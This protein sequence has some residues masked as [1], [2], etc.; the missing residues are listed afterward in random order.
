MI[1]V[2]SREECHSNPSLIHRSVY[3]FVLNRRGEVFIQRRSVEKDLYPGFY[4]ASATGHVEYGEGYD[5]AAWRELMEEL[6][7]DAPLHRLGKVK[8]FS[9]AE[10]EISMIYF[11]RY[12]GPMRL[13]RDEI[14]EGLFMTLEEIKRSIETGERRFAYGF[15]VA[16]EEFL[17]A[18]PMVR[19][20]L[21]LGEN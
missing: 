18:L 6:G 7:I 16:F 13:E 20:R 10:R 15:K 21:R 14:S 19:K 8:S 12:D 2:A 17:R 11:C 9:G 4:T 1:G 3:V 5:E